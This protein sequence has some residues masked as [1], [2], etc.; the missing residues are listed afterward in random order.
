MSVAAHD[1]CIT[2]DDMI[3]DRKTCRR[4]SVPCIREHIDIY[5]RVSGLLHFF[6]DPVAKIKIESRVTKAVL[7]ALYI[8]CIVLV[9]E[10]LTVTALAIDIIIR[11]AKGD[12]LHRCVL[13][14]ISVFKDL[15]NM[16]LDACIHLGVGKAQLLELSLTF[17]KREPLRMAL[18]I[19]FIK[20]FEKQ[21]MYLTRDN[22]LII[23][24][25]RRII[26]IPGLI[27]RRGRTESMIGEESVKTIGEIEHAVL[28]LIYLAISRIDIRKHEC[29]FEIQIDV[30]RILKMRLIRLISI[31]ERKV[32][33]SAAKREEFHRAVDDAAL[34][35]TGDRD[36]RIIGIDLVG[37]IT[38]ILR[39]SMG[40]VL[41]VTD[42][43]LKSL[44]ALGYRIFHDGRCV[45]IFLGDISTE[46]L[47]R[48]DLFRRSLFRNNDHAVRHVC[49][50]FTVLIRPDALIDRCD[51]H[52]ARAAGSGDRLIGLCRIT[53]GEH[54]LYEILHRCRIRSR[55]DR[56]RIAFVAI[57]RCRTDRLASVLDD[58][59]QRRL[60]IKSGEIFKSD[61]EEI[62][63]L[64]IRK[65]LQI[66]F[67]RY[68]STLDI[69]VR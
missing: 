66:D 22:T 12:D 31:V 54:I 3:I 28:F 32:I 56:A 36:P 21:S 34:T 49:R 27:S 40:T 2:Y 51:F 39:C 20:V 4:L 59:L 13:I 43:D 35:D 58:D 60:E 53:I 11:L 38:G 30:G 16:L 64:L 41:R 46:K 6:R 50:I 29:S 7:L 14:V 18:E 45:L 15:E 47:S 33:V 24:C 10:S 25:F 68:G 63:R 52:R 55:K 61:T 17:P 42:R 44:A 26:E 1:R 8:H 37:T 65:I 57:C 9:A 48:I 5:I 62:V 67:I 69:G 19:I 23:C